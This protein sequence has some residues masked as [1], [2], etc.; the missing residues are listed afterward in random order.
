KAE[1]TADVLNEK[2]D[3]GREPGT[4]KSEKPVVN[5]APNPDVRERE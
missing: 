4:R 3:Y 2:T 1:N 5:S